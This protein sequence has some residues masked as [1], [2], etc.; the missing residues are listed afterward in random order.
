MNWRLLVIRVLHG[1]G[2][3]VIGI[4]RVWGMAAE[5]IG[6]VPSRLLLHATVWMDPRPEEEQGDTAQLVLILELLI[7]RLA[8][9]LALAGLIS[10]VTDFGSNATNGLFG[11]VAQILPVLFLA[12]IV[13]GWASFPMIFE[14]IDTED[15]PELG[16][17]REREMVAVDTVYG[18]TLYFLLGEAA[19]LYSLTGNHQSSFGV[20]V[21]LLGGFLMVRDLLRI[22]LVRYELVGEQTQAKGAKSP[23]PKR[24]RRPKSR[25][26]RG[27]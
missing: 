18:L 6:W 19:A 8:S 14:Y 4:P 16:G 22:H 26:R 24:R 1:I 27:R 7:A 2:W 13:E 20:I 23:K 15:D 3:T 5:L 10:L 17:A 21:P 11:A 9:V 25:R 12:G